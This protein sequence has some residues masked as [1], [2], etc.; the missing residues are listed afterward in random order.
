MNAA[1]V[2][3]V[4]SQAFIAA[5]MV[6]VNRSLC[7]IAHNTSKDRVPPPVFAKDVDDGWAIDISDQLDR[8]D[9]SGLW[10]A[11]TGPKFTDRNK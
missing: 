1:Q 11:A 6:G 2:A 9:G 3:K 4:I 7:K 5:S 10:P 8:A